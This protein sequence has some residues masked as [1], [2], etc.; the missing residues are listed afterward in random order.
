[1]KKIFCFL[2]FIFFL[3]S[4]TFAQSS[5][6]NLSG[7]VIDAE[8]GSP[9]TGAS[10]VMASPKR[11]G[12]VTD[13][14]GRFTLQLSPGTYTLQ[15]AY[16]G[17]SPKTVSGIEVKAGQVNEVEV[18]LTPSRHQ[19]QE[20][21]VTAASARRESVNAI[22]SLQKNNTSVSDGI[23]AE[24]IRRTPDRN[25]GEVL[26][27][28][29]GTSIQDDKF[30]IVRGLSDRYNIATLNGAILPST[31][32]DRR[33]FSFDIIPS[34]MIDNVLINKTASPDL[35]GDF[36]GGIV[37]ITTKDIPFAKTFGI[38]VGA[39]FNSQSTGKDFNIG[40]MGSL[41]YLGF[42]DG[43]RALPS[44]FPSSTARYGLLSRENKILASQKL[45]NNYGDKYDG[46]A[47]PNFNLQANWGNKFD[48]KNGGTIGA[49]VSATYRNSQDIQ[50]NKRIEYEELG[51]ATNLSYNYNDTTYAFTT[52]LG[53]LANV[54]YKKGNSKIAWKN[55][56]NRIFDNSSLSR[57]GYNYANNQYV[58][59]SSGITVQ[60][61][62]FASQLEGEH[63]I[64]DKND[65][66]R[67]NL[68]YA[69]TSRDQ[70]DYRIL[71]YAKRI[72]EINDKNVPF[73]VIL[74]DTYRFWSSLYDNTFGGKIDYSLPLRWFDQQST[75]KAGLL[76]QYKIR[77]FESRTFR[78]EEGNLS[79]NF[80]TNLMT[81]SPERIF[82]RGN[83]YYNSSSHG[84]VYNEITNPNDKYDATSGL[85]AAYAMLDNKF[86]DKVRLVWGLRVENFD[87]TVNTKNTAGE[88][89]KIDRNYLDVLPS[90][91]FIYSINNKNNIRV[92]A[93]RT[94]SRPELREVAPFAYYDF[95]RNGIVVGNTNLERSQN[96]NLDL[97]Y[98]I[99]PTP[100]EIFS[101][102]GFYK[103]F[104]KPIEQTVDPGSSAT[105]L[106]FSY[107]NPEAA[108]IY[109]AELDV[110]K[111]LSFI[112]DGQFWQSLVF[113]LNAALIKSK[114]EFEENSGEFDP[115]RPLQG[116]SPYLFNAGL[117]YTSAD[118]WTFTGLFNRIGERIDAV[119]F[120]P[121]YPDIYENARSVVDLQVGKRFA[122]NKAELKLNVSDLLNQQ[123]VFY[124]NFSNVAARSY[125]QSEDRI[126]LSYLYGTRVS[127]LFSYNF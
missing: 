19:L 56:F 79:S 34:A 101:V 28:V 37:Q 78:V 43:T 88:S 8:S 74:R 3:F 103:H 112:G 99:F 55:T 73:T 50:Y 67:W 18:S 117:S 83:F 93:S 14:E 76:G 125:K 108:Q 124:Q 60:K 4:K 5:P 53:A 46:K 48:L 51:S 44:G 7:K 65:R 45:R 92:S 87:Y 114:V 115:N 58:N 106:I 122:K 52:N 9:L 29:S 16:V 41:D 104:K 62:L 61:T 113:S 75:F 6:V 100:G 24:V 38:S 15:F 72:E 105:N 94:V 17:Y 119:G 102:S 23:S 63:K 98:E 36:S 86:S 49:L 127:L 111:K 27:R 95:I 110:R 39:G 42:D 69:F 64:S 120:A 1:M 32:P 91:N 71:P 26:K 13:V 33:A 57:T 97:R 96:T 40:R 109:G 25:V 118:N 54:A 47:L 22:L 21:V 121:G 80:N 107:D 59:A 126:R 116:Q 2:L 84:F 11:T 81:L 77:D 85:Y 90:A 123:S 12:K 70:P 89:L 35:P 20:V 30:V 68:N 31:E 10:V 66:F 82:N